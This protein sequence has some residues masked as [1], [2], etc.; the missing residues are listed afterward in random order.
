M[1]IANATDQFGQH[2]VA[3]RRGTH[4]VAT[5]PMDADRPD[6]EPPPP[7][8]RDQARPTVQHATI[9]VDDD[10]ADL[11]DVMATQREARCLDIDHGEPHGVELRI[12]VPTLRRGCYI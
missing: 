1:S 3:G 2:L 10:K 7:A 11:Q 5:D 8:W 4:H 9:A 6:T 12:H